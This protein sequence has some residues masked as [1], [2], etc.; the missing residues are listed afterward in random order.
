MSEE[1]APH[2]HFQYASAQHQS[3]TA[4]AGMW[5]FLATEVLFFGGLV[6]AWMFCRHWQQGGFDA[7][8]RESVLSI[9]TINLFLLLTSS[10]VYTSG[11]VFIEMDQPRRL[12]Q[13]CVVTICLGTAF[14]GL[15]VWEWAIDIH[16]HLFPA[17][18]AFKITGSDEGGARLFWSFY[19]VATFLHALHMVAGIGAVGWIA[20]QA[21]AGRFSA[22]WA[23]P[24]E[25]VG[26]YWSFVDI[27][28]IVLYPLIYLVGRGS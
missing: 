2:H 22:N 23:I 5:L 19:F 9:G 13:C 11:L 18:A 26:L 27:V 7:G 28:W 15:K 8:G 4:I 1:I 10:F 16:E 3:D 20:V 6:L 14:L 17:M 25:V 12:V 21:R 24:V